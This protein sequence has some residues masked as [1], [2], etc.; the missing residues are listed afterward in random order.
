MG[1]MQFVPKAHYKEFLRYMN[2]LLRVCE[3]RVKYHVFFLSKQD[4]YVDMK[5]LFCDC[6]GVEQECFIL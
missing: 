2:L 4:V 1:A 3:G 5:L 6:F